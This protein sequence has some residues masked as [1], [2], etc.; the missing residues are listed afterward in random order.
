MALDDATDAKLPFGLGEVDLTDPAALF[1]T[2][3]A[4]IAGATIWN[5]A[6]SIGQNAASTVNQFLGTIL[7]T[8]PATGQDG[9]GGTGG[10]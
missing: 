9:D 3:I 5:M 6:D 2:V 7:G 1:A 10:V 8:N 4:L